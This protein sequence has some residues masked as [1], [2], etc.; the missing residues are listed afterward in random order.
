MISTLPKRLQYA[1]LSLVGPSS[2]FRIGSHIGRDKLVS[3]PRPTLGAPFIDRVVWPLSSLEEN[4]FRSLVISESRNSFYSS[5]PFIALV[6]NLDIGVLNYSSSPSN[7]S[8]GSRSWFFDHWFSALFIRC[9]SRQVDSS[10]FVFAKFN[11]QFALNEVVS[12]YS[13]VFFPTRPPPFFFSK[14]EFVIEYPSYS[15]EAFAFFPQ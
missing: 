7:F 6:R 8:L 13:V 3:E 12:P 2:S 4:F 11:P 14:P 15:C 9:I 10:L 5:A 1:L